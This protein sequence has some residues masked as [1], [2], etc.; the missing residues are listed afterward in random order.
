[1]MLPNLILYVG[2]AAVNP[3]IRTQEPF[4]S[5]DAE[6]L[7]CWCEVSGRQKI[8]IT[9]I[10][11]VTVAEIQQ[12]HLHPTF[13]IVKPPAM[14]AACAPFVKLNPLVSEIDLDK[15]QHTKERIYP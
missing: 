7:S 10:I 11:P 12:H 5:E 14:A 8:F 1:M 9:Q 3:K 6:G 15:C 13:S 4:F 2:R